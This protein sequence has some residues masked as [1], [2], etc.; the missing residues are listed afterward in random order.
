[1]NCSNKDLK[2]WSLRATRGKE[3]GIETGSAPVMSR[4]PIHFF[5]QSDE[6]VDCDEP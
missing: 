6:S 1:M 5:E 3:A 4:G 2:I